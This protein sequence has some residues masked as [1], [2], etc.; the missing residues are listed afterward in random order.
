ML[1]HPFSAFKDDTIYQMGSQADEIF[2]VVRVFTGGCLT[3]TPPRAF[4]ESASLYVPDVTHRMKD[5]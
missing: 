3:C 1:L 4:V 2:F 5:R